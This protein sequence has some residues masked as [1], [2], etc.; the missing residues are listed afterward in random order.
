MIKQWV[1]VEPIHK[2]RTRSSFDPD[3]EL[4][5]GEKDPPGVFNLRAAY[6]WTNVTC[7]KCKRLRK[8]RWGVSL[9]ICLAGDILH[10]VSWNKLLNTAFERKTK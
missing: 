5:C 4:K 6:R 3:W 8:K 9:V 2:A 1:R 7:P 10:R